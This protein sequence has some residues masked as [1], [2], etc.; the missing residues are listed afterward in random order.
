[1]TQLRI[2]NLILLV[3][4]SMGFSKKPSPVY[5]SPQSEQSSTQSVI[6]DFKPVKNYHTQVEGELI[7]AARIKAQ[8]V[9]TG[10]CFKEFI[11]SRKMIST[12]GR[13]NQEVIDHILSSRVEIPVSMYFR[14]MSF[15]FRCPVPTK[16]VAYREPPSSTIN[17]NRAVFNKSLNV[18]GWASTMSHEAS[19]ILG[20]EHSFK[21][22]PERDYSVPYSINAAFTACCQD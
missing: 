14:C 9:L 7:K 17:L 19:H 11:G 8:E 20:Y 12:G 18:C 16:A 22:T 15:G 5:D 1:M 4:L 21:W 13:S 2:A 10:S 3:F 6:L